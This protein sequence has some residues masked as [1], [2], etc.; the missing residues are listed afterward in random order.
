MRGS[1]Q[2]LAAALLVLAGVTGAAAQPAAGPTDAQ[3]KQRVDALL[4]QMTLEEK[5]GQLEQISGAAFIPGS[6]P[7]EP[8]I[9]AGGA[10]SVLWLNDTKKFNEL[11]KIAVEQSRLKIPLLFGLDVI[12]GYRT[13][14]PVPLAMAAS[15]DPAVHEKAAAIAAKE[16]RAAGIHWTFAPM[17]DIARDARWGRIVEGAGEDPYLG[18]AMAAAQVRGFQG[19][20]ARHA[21]PRAR[22]RQALRR[23]RRRRRRARLRPRLPLGRAAAQRLPP[24]VQG[25]G[26]RRGRHRHERLHG[27][28]QRAGG[29]RTTGC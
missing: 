15:W 23:L 17:L 18:A 2:V 20:E 9:R 1:R 27:P 4:A 11:Q 19:P 25:R 8:T 13:I 16:A 12:H 10:G 3:V 22:L 6:K 5:V 26:R 29:R 14:F 28:Q 7:P 21:G 24:A